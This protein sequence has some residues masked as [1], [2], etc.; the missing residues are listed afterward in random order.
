LRIR[1][2]R[3]PRG[4]ETPRTGRAR[5]RTLV[6]ASLIGFFAYTA[7]VFAGGVGCGE[8]LRSALRGLSLGATPWEALASLADAPA[9]YLGAIRADAPVEK[10]SID[11][12]FKHLHVLHEMRAEALEEGVLLTSS[13]DYVPAVITHRGRPVDVELRLTGGRCD[14]F[15]GEKW[16]MRVQ[17]K[18]GERL[19][20][21][22]RF[23]LQDPAL[24]GF[25]AERFFLEHL[26]RE[27]V[28]APRYFFVDLTLNGKDIGLMALQEHFAKELLESQQRREGV[29]LRFDENSLRGGAGDDGAGGPFDSYFNARIRPFGSGKVG[30]SPR[31]SAERRIA[32]GLL[33]GYLAGDLSPSEVFDT[34]LMGR[35]L[36]VAELWRSQQ[37]VRWNNLRF[38]LNPIT[39]RLEP[40]GHNGSL[41]LP[42]TDSGLLTLR[43]PFSRGLLEDP[44][45]GAA[46]V[47]ALRRGE[48]ELVDGTLIQ[49]AKEIEEADLALLHREFP[50][51]G[52]YAFAPVVD[53][54]GALRSVDERS[55][56]LFA[57]SIG[58]AERRHPRVVSAYVQRDERGHYL[59]LANALPVPVSLTEL[60]F[61]GDGGD[62][63]EGPAAQA[64]LEL[65]LA[66]P[67]TASQTEP[68]SL[69]IDFRPPKRSNGALPEIEG[70]AQVQGQ[71]RGYRFR[72]IPYDPPLRRNPVPRAT[73]EEVLAQHPFLIRDAQTDVLSARPGRWSVRGSLV[74][75][76]GMGLRLP[77]GT[78]LR[79]EAR[80]GLVATGPLDF[81]GTEREPVVLEGPAGESP[82]ELWS[83][84]AVL[85]AERP[86]RWSFVE[87][88][89]TGGFEKDGWLLDV[90]V[91]FHRAPVALADCRLSGNRSEDALNIVDTSFTLENVEILDAASD[92]FDAD[93]TEGTVEGGAI[94]RIGGDGIDVSGSEVRL[95]GVRLSEIRDKAV[96]VGEGSQLSASALTIEKA[97]TAFASKDDS[98]GEI[99]DSAISEI[100]HVALMAYVKKP[101]YGP[102][103]LEAQDNRISG[104]GRL[105][106]AQT[107]SRV[108]L[109]G[110][111]VPEED[112]DVDRL[113]K[114]GYMQK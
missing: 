112:I 61:A 81:E 84:V 107:G 56:G 86:S 13:E 101:Q 89:D 28:L 25:Q 9:N 35:F 69:R 2:L 54:A 74:V 6:A 27:A 38:Y 44:A 10:L 90:G 37:A 57:P 91:L 110:S 99:R 71:S 49:W 93:F 82:S 113:Y 104:V 80:E 83:G 100:A 72:A 111:A 109:D 4:R 63:W 88:R 73:L 68:R 60:R 26:R 97:G 79:F 70:V 23:I 85:G 87:V 22:R 29:I 103:E 95:R 16:P 78:T 98:W 55:I 53:R 1:S 108:V 18:R 5:R 33:R 48:A 59:E 7:A 24:R 67:P 21:M 114:E 39:E 11:I 8:L 105:A 52:R 77:A 15:E 62:A 64:G 51:R 19:F 50:F 94:A 58:G 42:Y 14:Q 43:E 20:G 3:V 40:I 96:S 31:L 45:V 47:A 75:P 46:F 65:P 36:A 76:E 30:R 17:V 41:Q 34:E 12:K 32:T 66:L 102:A 106:I 92:A